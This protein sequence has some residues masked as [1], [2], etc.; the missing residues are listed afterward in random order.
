LVILVER[1]LIMFV[2]GLIVGLVVG[3]VI[4]GLVGVYVYPQIVK[5]S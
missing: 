4:G 5:K 2:F 1:R 3:A